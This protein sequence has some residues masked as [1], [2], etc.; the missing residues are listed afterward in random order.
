MRSVE[1][2]GVYQK[3]SSDI[4]SSRQGFE[5]FEADA[6]VGKVMRVVSECGRQ[7]RLMWSLGEIVS[8]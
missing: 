3:Q 6:A 8:W 4:G 7:E 5:C 1:L 2:R